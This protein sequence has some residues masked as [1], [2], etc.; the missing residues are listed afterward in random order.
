MC[1]QP[2]AKHMQLFKT[3]FQSRHNKQLYFTTGKIPEVFQVSVKFFILQQLT[4]DKVVAKAE[5]RHG[6]YLS[7]IRRGVAGGAHQVIPILSTG[8]AL[9]E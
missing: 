7:F 5:L 4:P 1:L 9:T 2:S 6:K 8:Y 3:R